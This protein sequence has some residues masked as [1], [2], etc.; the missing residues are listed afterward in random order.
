MQCKQV[1]DLTRHRK[2]TAFGRPFSCM[3]VRSLSIRRNHETYE[4]E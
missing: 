4:L 1:P 3:Q 2:T